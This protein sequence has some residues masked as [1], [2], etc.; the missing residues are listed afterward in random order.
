MLILYY[1]RLF[2]ISLFYSG[3]SDHPLL[4]IYTSRLL[5]KPSTS[6]YTLILYHTLTIFKTFIFKKGNN[7]Y[8]TC[9]YCFLKTFVTSKFEFLPIHLHRNFQV[10]NLIPQ[11]FLQLLN[12]DYIHTLCMN[13][14]LFL[15]PQLLQL[16]P[17]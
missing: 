8:K 5:S 11:A 14:F 16:Q 1:Q 9:I 13:T 17:A 12:R 3:Q 7:I 15:V 10:Y 6:P 4:A 2:L